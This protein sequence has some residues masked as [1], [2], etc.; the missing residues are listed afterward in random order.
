MP[1]LEC[2]GL[3]KRY[4]D[5]VVYDGVD[6]RLYRGDKVAQPADPTN[7]DTTKKFA[8]WYTDESGGTAF[9]FDS[10][11]IRED[12]SLYAGWVRQNVAE[13]E[14][15]KTYTVSGSV[16]SGDYDGIIRLELRR[17]DVP[18]DTVTTTMREGQAEYLF[19][20]VAPGE[21]EIVAVEE[22]NGKSVMLTLPLSIGSR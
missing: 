13:E 21:Y 10:E 6:F 1:V 3:T 11:V 18:L 5:N 4:G 7:T 22:G 20:R 8:G 15:R 17:D 16:A 12:T 2:R 14:T 19:Q 9:D